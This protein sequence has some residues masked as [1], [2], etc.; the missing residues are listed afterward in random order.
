MNQQRH[1][2]RESFS[3]LVFS[4]TGETRK[5]FNVSRFL[6]RLSFF[7]L[8]LICLAA[9][10]MITKVVMGQFQQRQLRE[11]IAAQEEQVR[12][13]ESE[14]QTLDNE[15][16]S[17]EKEV[18]SLRPSTGT[19]EKDSVFPKRYPCSGHS[20]LTSSYSDEMPYLT[21]M[22]S[23]K[24]KIVA[25]G[26]GTVTFI[27]SS[28]AYPVIIEIAHENGYRTR[29]MCHEEVKCRVKAGASVK[30]GDTLY[31]V[32]KDETLVDYQVAKEELID[33]MLIIDAKG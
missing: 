27:G 15:K 33:P 25:A 9:G 4:H 8:F 7:I 32:S 17:L 5:Q 12:Q 22:V 24:S 3:I 14:N 20:V 2:R 18:E 1:K 16:S 21:L 19:G 26:N 13:L 29:Y 11:L 6:L 30:E 28:S 23:S 31:T 10:W